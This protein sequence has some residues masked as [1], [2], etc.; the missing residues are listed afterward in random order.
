MENEIVVSVICLTYNHAPYIRQCLDGFVMQKTNFAF[1][2]IVHDDASTDDTQS[3]I[4]EYA[5]VYPKLFRPILQKENQY[6]KHMQI[7]KS[8]IFP[9][10]RGKYIAYCEG[11]DY[12]TDPYKLQKQVD[13]LE[14]CPQYIF[15]CHRYQIYDTHNNT[16]SL[17]YAQHLFQSNENV[18]VTPQVQS[19]TWVTKLLSMVIRTTEYLKA[20]E[21]AFCL[22]GDTRDSY[23]FYELL[24]LGNG[25]ALNQFM[26]VYRQQ[27]SGVWSQLN[28]VQ[29]AET[30]YLIFEKIYSKNSDDPYVLY[31]LQHNAIHYLRLLSCWNSKN[32]KVFQ[33]I[34][35]YMDSTVLKTNAIL[36]FILPFGFIQ[37]I[38]KLLSKC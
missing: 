3:I 25:L 22:Y 34:Y 1:E 29:K 6:S 16:F 33:H 27:A 37:A 11:D 2:V 8:Y 21:R 31:S 17:D 5:D 19:T 24:K 9:C 12:W 23:V 36:S 32:R 14:S 20:Q 4:Q 30:N 26:G 15:C 10:C 28:E 13:I 18:I 38:K 7:G 35:G